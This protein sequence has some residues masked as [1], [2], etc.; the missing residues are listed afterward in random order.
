MDPVKKQAQ[1]TF[2]KNKEAYVNSTTHGNKSDL[3]AITDWLNPESSWTVLD[4]A[5]GGGHVAK[6][7]SPFV[8]TVIASDLTKEML[9]N[10]ARHLKEL[11][12]LLYVIADAEQ[13]PFIENSFDAVTCRIAPH[14]FPNP[15]HFLQETERVLKPGGAFVM[16]DNISSEDDNFDDFYNTFEKMRDPSHYRALK[17]S[18]WKELMNNSGLTIKQEIVRRK[19][20]P[21]KDW[22]E[23]TLSGNEIINMENFFLNSP[24]A[25]KNYFQINEDKGRIV[26]F[27]IDE[28][29]VHCIKE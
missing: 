17:V 3:E 21:F 23:R 15:D 27:S 8:R 14:H 2:S 20:L 28:W 29:M 24:A 18:E 13:L 6:Q 12:N 1:N 7:L 9:S 11:E 26:D 5:T 4:I 25:A 16:V 10:T 19:T 22:A